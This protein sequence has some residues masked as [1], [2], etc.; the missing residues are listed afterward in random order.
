MA[1][2]GWNAS[3]GRSCSDCCAE[4]AH[5]DWRCLQP[6]D[7]KRNLWATEL[8]FFQTN[9]F[10]FEFCKARNEIKMF[11]RG[12]M[13]AVGLTLLLWLVLLL[14]DFGTKTLSHTEGITIGWPP[15]PRAV[16]GHS[17]EGTI[18]PSLWL[19]LSG[20]II[21]QLTKKGLLAW[22]WC[23]S[24]M[25]PCIQLTGA[26][27]TSC[28]G[29]YRLGHSSVLLDLA[30]KQSLWSW[31]KALQHIALPHTTW[32]CPPLYPPPLTL[33]VIFLQAL[34]S[35]RS[36]LQAEIMWGPPASITNSLCFS[37]SC[38]PMPQDL[39][40]TLLGPDGD[41]QREDLSVSIFWA[42]FQAHA[43][44]KGAWGGGRWKLTRLSPMASPAAAHF[45]SEA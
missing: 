16:G 22:G 33:A 1:G 17:A 3:G 32:R 12:E 43:W 34:L 27:W 36:A 38:P 8:A 18:W 35:A 20:H 13:R 28:L 39:L 7:T 37:P 11:S 42:V 23:V 40:F 45:P 25:Q 4:L 30:G 2:E 15:A 10:K 41:P 5:L 44:R 31:N 26:R 6:L 19:I 24:L 29:S 9:A 14:K 21:S